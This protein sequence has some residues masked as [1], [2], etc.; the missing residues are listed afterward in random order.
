MSGPDGRWGR[1]TYHECGAGASQP[2][3]RKPRTRAE[4]E[5]L[6]ESGV[7]RIKYGVPGISGSS[8]RVLGASGQICPRRSGPNQVPGALDA[9]D[10]DDI[11][12]SFIDP[13]CV[14]SQSG[15]AIHAAANSQVFTATE[16]LGRSTS[17]RYVALEQIHRQFAQRG[18]VIDRKDNRG[19]SVTGP[20]VFTCNSEE[21]GRG[22]NPLTRQ[23]GRARPAGL[24]LAPEGGRIPGHQ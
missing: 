12:E 6:K 1:A 3:A 21:S 24:L 10:S 2:S 20:G 5:F 13:S 8:H 14:S 7:H 4:W 18:F 16:S 15:R 19:N 22:L 23:R 17:D 9:L 11:G